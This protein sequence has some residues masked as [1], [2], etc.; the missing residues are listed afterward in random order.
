MFQA[1][2][3]IVVTFSYQFN[4]CT[5]HM[6]FT[7]RNQWVNGGDVVAI[8]SSGALGH[9]QLTGKIVLFA[10]VKGLLRLMMLQLS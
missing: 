8:D 6:P 7:S 10:G 9:P 5:S 3:A 4:T 2:F 1:I